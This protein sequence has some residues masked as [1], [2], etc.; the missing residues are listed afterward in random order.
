MTKR[1]TPEALTRD[2]LMQAAA[3]VDPELRRRSQLLWEDRVQST[4]GPKAALTPDDVVRAAMQLAD[5]D[6][7]GAVTMSAVSTRI[8]YTTM[9]VYRYFPS[10]EALLDAIVDAALG[11]PPRPSE[12]RDDWRSELARWA[13][14][15]RAMLCARPWLA[16]LPFVAAP[17][18]PNWLS[19]SEAVIDAL[20]TTGLD[21]A[22][23]GEMLSVLDGYT[24]GASDT[25]I[26]LARARARG[27]SDA[28][29]AAAVGADLGRAIGDP[30]FPRFAAL[31]TTPPSRPSRTM[32]ESFEFGLARVL[33]GI[34][35][36]VNGGRR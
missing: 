15:K 3:T 35:R 34:E 17:H 36:Y 33:D 28:E 19:W 23:I 27:T 31:L 9:A 12:P 32:D 8:G 25:A 20:S 6:G 18:G 21:S 2:D 26:S 14:A 11:L 7:L 1:K 24:R 30:R 22:D 10:K 5:E 16:E 4:R 29:W 13:R